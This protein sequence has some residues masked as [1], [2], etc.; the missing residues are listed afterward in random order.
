M[1]QYTIEVERRSET[2]KNVNRR[3]RANG[4]IPAVVYGAGKDSVP[5]KVHRKSLLDL[6]KSSGSDNA[7]FLLKL[8]GSGQERHA[9][10]RDMHVDPISRQVVHIDFLRVLMTEK[11]RVKVPIEVVGTPYGVK[12]ESGVLDFVHREVEVECLPGDIPKHLELDVTGLHVGQHAEAK[13]L[14]LPP[15]VALVTD[16]GQVLVSI[17]HS[18]LEEAPAAAPAESLLE[19]DRAEPEVIKRGKTDEE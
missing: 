9:M 10:I 7:I 14:V 11:V 13:D 19:A 6:M 8:A 12:N 2:G 3:L 4:M 15:G 17:S 16:P 18:R 5:I 1:D